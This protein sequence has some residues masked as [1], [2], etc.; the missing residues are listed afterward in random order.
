MRILVVGAGSIGGYF[1]GRL[2]E[3]GADVT[4]LVR[5]RRAEIL[6]RTGLV[7]R[8][9]L[10]DF[11]EP[12]PKLVT[13]DRLES[14]FDLILLSCK[15]Y[16]LADAIASFAPA[17][18]PD[19]TILPLLNGM[20]HLDDLDERFGAG[21]TLGGLC[22][23]S[24][25]LDDEGHILHLNQVHT[26]TFGERSGGRSPRAD[27]IATLFATAGFTTVSSE[28]I[29]QEMWEKFVFIA[30]LAGITCLMRASVGEVVAAGGV[31]YATVLLD[32]CAAIAARNGHAPREVVLSHARATITAPDS[33]MTAS[34]LRDIEAG[35]RTEADHIFGDLLQRTGDELK[36]FILSIVYVNLKSYEQ[37]RK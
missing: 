22:M 14:P 5:P 7:I 37:R 13:A 15:A 33:S 3:A 24:T 17:V 25:V 31:E 36:S 9:K 4:F 19:T 23:I 26:L 20:R 34:M 29:L 1:G 10:G 32:E 11:H 16:D 21:R 2:I 30:S 6:T 12:A 18:G 8:S 28:A 35:G 27:A